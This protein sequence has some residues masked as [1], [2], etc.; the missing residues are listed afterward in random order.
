[1]IEVP[2]PR[3]NQFSFESTSRQLT[4]LSGKFSTESGDDT[5]PNLRL[6]RIAIDWEVRTSAKE[7][8]TKVSKLTLEVKQANGYPKCAQCC[9]QNR[10]QE[11]L[12]SAKVSS[13]VDSHYVL[14]SKTI[15][16]RNLSTSEVKMGT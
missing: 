5:S 11:R 6:S 2:F 15:R 10:L 7:S 12:T 16:V 14:L 9:P 4:Q 3:A 1:M 8:V 13:N